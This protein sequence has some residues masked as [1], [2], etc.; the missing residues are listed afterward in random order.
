MLEYSLKNLNNIYY[1]RSE[2]ELVKILTGLKAINN[3]L[4]VLFHKESR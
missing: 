2:K 3:S 1:G 4:S